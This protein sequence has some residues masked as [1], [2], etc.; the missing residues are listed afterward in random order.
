MLEYIE[1]QFNKA[2]DI[3]YCQIILGDIWFVSGIRM[4]FTNKNKKKKEII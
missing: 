4:K 1:L 3:I 2:F